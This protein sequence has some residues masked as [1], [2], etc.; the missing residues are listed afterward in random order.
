MLLSAILF[1]T[2]AFAGRQEG[3]ILRGSVV[4]SE[5]APA[6][7]ATVYLTNPEGSI[8]VGNTA[9][10]DGRFELRAAEGPYTLTVSL[11]GYRDA[12][13]AV[14]LK[15]TSVELDPIRLQ[16][17]TEML[18]EAVVQAVMPKTRVT[19]EGLA[20]SVRGSVLENAG[21]A[22]DVL[23]KVPGLIKGQNGI[24]VLG[25]GAPVIYI[26]GHKVTDSGELDRLLSNEVQSVEVISNPGAQYDATV[27][28]V[29]RIRT[30]KRQGEGFGFDVSLTDSQ[31]MTK[32]EHNDPGV[33][34]N[35][36]YRHGGMDFFGGVNASKAS[37]I[38]LSDV[39]QETLGSTVFKQDGII[40]VDAFGKAAGVNGGF[41]WQI[42]DNH[43]AGF[44]ADWN[45]TFSYGEKIWIDENIFLDGTPFDHL[46]TSS[47]GS[48]GPRAPFSLS[49]NAYYNGTVGK[50]GIDLNVDYFD[51]ANSSQSV[52]RESS[53]IQDGTVSTVSSS[54]NKLYAAK[55]VLSYPVWMGALQLGTEETF[56]RRSDDYSLTGAAVPASTTRVKEDNAAAFANYSFMVGQIGQVSAGLRYEHVDYAYDDLTGEDSFTRRYDNL[57]PS[58]SF[59]GAFGPVQAM[60]SYSARTQ[61]PDFSTLSSAIRYTNRYTLQ[62][63]NAALQPQTMQEFSSTFLWKFLTLVVNYNRT[64][65]PVVT[66]VTP[67]NDE[68]V[69]MLKPY[70]LDRP[71]RGLSAF[72]NA[73][74]TIGPWVMNYTVGMQQTWLNVDVTVP[75]SGTRAL[76]FNGKPIWIAQL[77]NSFIL[78]KGWQLELGGEYHSPGYMQNAMVTNHFLD[79]SAAVQKSLLRDGS[80]VL[81]LEGK[82]LAGLGHSNVFTDLGI[83]RIT[84]SLIFDSRR[85]VFSVRYRFNSADSKYKGTGAGN[86]VRSR[87]K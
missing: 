29:V 80:L 73:S 47:E 32:K 11:V 21:S 16:D 3:T 62:S 72:L 50:L 1:P 13:Q 59:A 85:L 81:R 55:L 68:G 31:S 30:V 7:F 37:E 15:G 22:R 86:D 83:Y 14:S 65:D 41:N 2:G 46:Q 74:P 69:I 34:L 75:G 28:A 70:N 25:K 54:E 44:K 6:A 38:Q 49:T 57:F 17:D 33:V 20:T 78:K 48:N 24:E 45:R 76:S 71:V 12:S 8:V 79:L 67:Y 39:V 43:F 9:D 18:G 61:R 53:D 84:Q 26:N 40:D 82:D 23:G 5:G 51:M 58:L 66:W 60:L 10:G 77:N 35:A 4:D 56:S 27:R 87:M 19:G 52:S 63:G 36:N 42:A 64:D